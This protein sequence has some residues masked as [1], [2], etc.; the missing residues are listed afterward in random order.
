MRVLSGPT[1]SAEAVA[2]N[3][4]PVRVY[5][6]R[7]DELPLS[8]LDQ[9][10]DIDD[11]V[12]AQDATTRAQVDAAGTW[13]ADALYSG[14]PTLASLRLRAG[15]SQAEFALRCGLKQPHVSRYEAGKHAPGVFQ[16][17]DMA[18]VLGVSL[19]VLVNALK[20]SAEGLKNEAV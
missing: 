6:L 15:L 19:D 1:V 17:Q 10:F 14:E 8:G 20:R 5:D 2:S 18:Q 12:D 3:P 11:Y 7:S 9:E 4:A 13:V 16:A